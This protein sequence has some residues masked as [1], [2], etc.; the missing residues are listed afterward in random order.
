MKTTLFFLLG[1]IVLASCSK[2]TG[3]DDG[4]LDNCMVA[5]LSQQSDTAALNTYFTYNTQGLPTKIKRVG[6]ETNFSYS[7]N[8]VF[9]E[10]AGNTRVYTIGTDTLALYSVATYNANTDSVVYFY[11]ADKYLIKSIRYYNG[12]KKDS[13]GYVVE[14]G[15]VTSMTHYNEY[16]YVNYF[17]TFTYYSNLDAKHWMYTKLAG[18]YGYNYY[19][20]LGKP[21]RNLVKSSAQYSDVEAYSY[22]FDK[23][24]KVEKIQFTV[25]GLPDLVYILNVGYNCK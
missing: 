5:R 2:Q 23:N 16:G 25:F 14:N 4:T 6:Y 11:N 18:D 1:L 13:I 21:N 10:E 19:P 8:K 12:I 20:W 22:T 15:N 3:A 7:G 24:G 17:R 9:Q